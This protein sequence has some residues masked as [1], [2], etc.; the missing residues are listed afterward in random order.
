MS[1][2]TQADVGVRLE[3]TLTAEQQASAT[4]LC[5]EATAII[6]DAAGV[7]EGDVTD[8]QT[9]AIFKGL[10]VSMACR[11]MASPQGLRS[12]S[13]QLGAHIRTEAYGSEAMALTARERSLVR[14]A[15]NGSLTTIRT[16]VVDDSMYFPELDPYF[17]GS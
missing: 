5:A 2:A 4:Q 8:S 17:L 12:A 3:K 10:T 1:F 15:A 9:L 13:T 11:T 14:G 16:P 6:C 7:A